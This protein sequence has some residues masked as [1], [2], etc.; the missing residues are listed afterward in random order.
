MDEIPLIT[1]RIA[2][3]LSEPVGDVVP[4]DGGITNRNYRVA[5]GDHD[6]VVRL[7][8]KDTGLL[9]IDRDAECDANKLAA[10]LGVAPR[11]C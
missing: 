6:Y 10:E 1:A 11:S 3:L 7:P 9:G 8:G 5:F 2:A 4:L